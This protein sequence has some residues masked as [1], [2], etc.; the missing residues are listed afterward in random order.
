MADHIVEIEAVDSDA[1]LRTFLTALHDHVA[2]PVRGSDGEIS[3]TITMDRVAK[4]SYP[5]ET[6]AKRLAGST[7]TVQVD[8][9]AG[10]IVQALLAGPYRAVPVLDGEA[11]VGMATERSVLLPRVL[12]GHD[13][14]VQRIMNEPITAAPDDTVGQVRDVMETDDIGRLPVVEDGGL[15][16]IVDWNALLDLERPKSKVTRGHIDRD[17]EQTPD[18]QI[19]VQAVMDK[20]PFTVGTE[21][22]LTTIADEMQEREISYA[23]VVDGGELVGVVTCRDL[24]ELVGVRDAEEGVF[25][26]FSGLQDVEG[27]DRMRVQSHVEDRL[28]KIARIEGGAEY[29]YLHVKEYEKDGTRSKYSLRTRLMTPVGPFFAKGHG[30]ELLD[31]LDET[32]DRLERQI[33]KAHDKRVEDR[34][35]RR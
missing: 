19:S 25:L 20:Q 32:L 27:V 4:R 26:Q 17:G 12:E 18:D 9:D 2:L 10:D 33:R 11:Y 24:L 35:K 22:T 8:D 15:I 6:K 7:T 30:Y 5:V 31:V 29:F 14:P 21:T 13:Q 34:R 23:V 1:E 28:Q 16:G 3:G